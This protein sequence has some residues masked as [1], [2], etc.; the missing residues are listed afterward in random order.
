MFGSPWNKLVNK[1]EMFAKILFK[2]RS[3]FY[4][5]VV[6]PHPPHPTAFLGFP[7]ASPTSSLASLCLNL[8]FI[9]VLLSKS[10]KQYSNYCLLLRQVRGQTVFSRKRI[11]DFLAVCWGKLSLKRGQ[12]GSFLSS[13]LWLS[14]SYHATV[15]DAGVSK[16]TE[17][18]PH[19]SLDFEEVG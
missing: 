12:D 11:G 6:P 5:T 16:K 4:S 8:I 15:R 19:T 10:D 7:Q 18:V 1:F 2:V 9:F 17:W 3:L 14:A 13:S